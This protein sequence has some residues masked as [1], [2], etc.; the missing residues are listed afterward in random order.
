MTTLKQM[1]EK[2]ANFQCGLY[3]KRGLHP[4]QQPYWD[5]HYQGFLAGAEAGFAAAREIERDENN[6]DDMNLALPTY[7]TFEDWLKDGG[8]SE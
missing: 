4:E 6:P 8:E 2:Y 1:A 7:E 3:N 5:Y